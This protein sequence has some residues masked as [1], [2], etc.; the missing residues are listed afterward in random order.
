RP[1]CRDRIEVERELTDDT[2]RPNGRK[3]RVS[4]PFGCWVGPWGPIPSGLLVHH[5]CQPRRTGPTELVAERPAV[6]RE[7]P[8]VPERTFVRMLTARGTVPKQ[9]KRRS[10]AAIKAETR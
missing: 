5:K 7:R 3:V 4:L 10:A 9:R 6:V 1:F 8:T 2:G